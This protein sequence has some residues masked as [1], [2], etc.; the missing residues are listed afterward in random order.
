MDAPVRRGSGASSQ[1]VSSIAPVL[2]AGGAEDEPHGLVVLVRSGRRRA[3]SPSR[4]TRSSRSRSAPSSL[5]AR[6][7]FCGAASERQ[8]VVRVRDRRAPARACVGVACRRRRRDRA[9]EGRADDDGEHRVPFGAA[10]CLGRHL[11]RRRPGANSFATAF[12]AAAARFTP[13]VPV[14]LR[15]EVVRARRVAGRVR[16]RRQRSGS[17]A[18][19]A[20]SRRCRPR[21]ATPFPFRT[22]IVVSRGRRRASSCTFRPSATAVATLAAS[23]SGLSQSCTAAWMFDGSV[24]RSE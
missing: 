5:N 6:P 20:G 15:V 4:A 10:R 16:R 2:A 19:R 18:A 8:R 11:P 22:V 3:A 24:R 17:R 14:D 13:R 1:F 23:T 9:V 21:P 12:A 7:C